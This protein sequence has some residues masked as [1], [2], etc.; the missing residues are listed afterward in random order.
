MSTI[1][2]TL[3]LKVDDNGFAAKLRADAEAA[4]RLGTDAQS[5]QKLRANAGT[6]GLV[7]QLERLNATAGRVEGYQN[8]SRALQTLGAGH[9]AARQEVERTTAA[10]AQ[11][12]RRK[13]FFDRSK[14]NNSPNY[15]AFKASGMVAEADAA[16]RKAAREHTAATRTAGR[17]QEAFQAQKT[18]LRALGQELERAGTPLHQIA[19]VQAGLRGRIEQTT[20]AIH[21]QARA[22][23]ENREAAVA[24]LRAA[25]QGGR[26]GRRA[27]EGRAGSGFTGPSDSC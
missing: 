3:A 15:P 11:A 14:A 25:V 21:R 20:A 18:T 8:A 22:H 12:Q 7:R 17:T 27:R 2:S 4:R 5:L 10:L 9:R 23:E 6:A 13:D 24:G 19:Q 26:E 16:L 1:T